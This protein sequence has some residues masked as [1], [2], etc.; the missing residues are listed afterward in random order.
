ML[1]HKLR[2]GFQEALAVCEPK[3]NALQE[4]K[5]T[6]KRT[7]AGTYKVDKIERVTRLHCISQHRIEWSQLAAEARCHWRTVPP[8]SHFYSR[9]RAKFEGKKLVTVVHGTSRQ[10]PGK[11]GGCCLHVFF[12]LSI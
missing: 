2:E 8:P 7:E 1:Y 11:R 5:I 4:H 9:G 6:L 3:P 12:I 10:T